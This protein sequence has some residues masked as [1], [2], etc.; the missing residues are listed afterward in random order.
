MNMYV[1][2]GPERQTLKVHEAVNR[3][4]ECR[5]PDNRA[6]ITIILRAT[7]RQGTQGLERQGLRTLFS[8]V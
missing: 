4:F 3:G 8:P 2:T 7:Y 5:S 1:V 6:E